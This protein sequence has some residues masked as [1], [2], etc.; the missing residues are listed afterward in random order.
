LGVTLPVAKPVHLDLAILL[1]ELFELGR[2]FADVVARVDSVVKA[3]PVLLGN[4]LHTIGGVAAVWLGC[5]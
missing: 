1:A 5:R 2:S 3:Y 4:L